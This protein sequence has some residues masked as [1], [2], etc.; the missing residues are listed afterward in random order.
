MGILE[1]VGWCRLPRLRKRGRI[2]EL[3]CLLLRRRRV[4]VPRKLGC[5]LLPLRKRRRVDELRCP[6]LRRGVQGALRSAREIVGY[7][8]L[9]FAQQNTMVHSRASYVR[10]NVRFSANSERHAEV[11][12]LYLSD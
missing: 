2:D 9:P 7:C 8:G 12:P 5:K 1:K 3:H 10:G 6:L 11:L 4:S